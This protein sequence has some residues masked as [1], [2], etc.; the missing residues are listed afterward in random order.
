MHPLVLM[1]SLPWVLPTQP[2][3]LLQDLLGVPYVD[4]AVLDER[5]R[6]T[7]FTHPEATLTGPG[8]NCSGFT[9]A[10]AR[11]LLNYTGTV[12]DATRDRLGDSGRDAKRGRDWDFGWD[13]ILNLSEGHRRRVILPEGEAPIQGADGL[14]L[15]GFA[16]ND[17]ACWQRVLPQIRAGYVY[18]CSLSKALKGGHV[19]HYHAVLL[20][21]DAQGSVWLY[22]TL[23]LGHSHRLNLTLPGG[24]QRMQEMFRGNKRILILEVDREASSKP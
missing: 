13:L 3:V 1:A 24:L 20:L 5:S 4:D 7:T 23:P 19:Q 10:C 9:I 8:L 12:D 15:R 22:Q 17:P 21:R 2:E 14:T 6:W 16:M 18:L 11:R